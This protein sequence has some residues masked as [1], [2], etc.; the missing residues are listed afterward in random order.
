MNKL[1]KSLNQK[2]Y[3][4]SFSHKRISDIVDWF[5]KNKPA[6]VSNLI[7]F[8]ANKKLENYHKLVGILLVENID[9]LGTKL[10]RTMKESEFRTK[11]AEIYDK[12]DKIRELLL[13]EKINKSDI[14]SNEKE[15][16]FDARY[17]L[18]VGFDLD[19]L[20]EQD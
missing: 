1:V 15:T 10:I 16:I 13:Q 8:N 4:I 7:H 5:E 3:Y 14:A 6:D 18:K 11:L 17:L 20:K 2:V 12:D 19:L 9:K